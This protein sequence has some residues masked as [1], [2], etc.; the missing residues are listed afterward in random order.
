MK[1]YN[2]GA[3]QIRAAAFIIAGSSFL[4]AKSVEMQ[5]SR[6]LQPTIANSLLCFSKAF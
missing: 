2:I 3:P 4:A 5:F 1:S 6:I